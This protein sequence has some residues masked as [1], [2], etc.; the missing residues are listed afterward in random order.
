MGICKSVCSSCSDTKN[1]GG[2]SNN[3]HHPSH[4]HNGGHSG[5]GSHGGGSHRGGGESKCYTCNAH[6]NQRPEVG[7]DDY[8]IQVNAQHHGDHTCN[9]QILTMVFNHP[10]TFINCS[11]GSLYGPNNKSEIKVKLR[12]HNNPND[13]IGM[14][15]FTVKSNHKDLKIIRCYINDGH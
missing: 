1:T 4:N 10:A 7:R 15:D 8:R 6:I 3:S 14:G 11:N 5:G 13:N 12:Y 2:N 9:E